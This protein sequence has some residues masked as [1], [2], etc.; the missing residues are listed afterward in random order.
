M[1]FKDVKQSYPIYILDNQN[2]TV[3]NG[4]VLSVS[5]PR[6]DDNKNNYMDFQ[7]RPT[8]M[9]IDLTIESE[10]KTAT[11][12]VP[13]NQ[14]I[15][16]AK[17]LVLILDKADLI[18]EIEC[19]KTNAEQLIASIDK[20]KDILEKSS[21][22]LENLNPAFKEKKETEER[23]SKLESSMDDIKKLIETMSSKLNM[24]QG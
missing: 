15:A 23:F 3:S 4:K 12:T 16:R 7:F 2:I 6:I 22:L 8:Q 10:G 20:Q 19:L 24:T 5:F 18:S 14:S 1:L 11:Y 9:V 17:N 21:A 13:E